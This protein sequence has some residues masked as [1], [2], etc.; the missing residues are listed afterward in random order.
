MKQVKLFIYNYGSTQVADF[1][2]HYHDAAQCMKLLNDN[3]VGIYG[4]LPDSIFYYIQYKMK[5]RTVYFVDAKGLNIDELDSRIEKLKPVTA[6][7]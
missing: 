1:K 5:G 2:N 7:L 4:K 6:S 3:L